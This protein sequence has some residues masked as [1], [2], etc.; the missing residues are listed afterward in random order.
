MKIKPNR[1]SC[2]IAT[3]ELSDAEDQDFLSNLRAHVKGNNARRKAEGLRSLYVKV[4][5]RLGE[6]NPNAEKYR[7]RPSYTNPYQCVKLGDARFGDIYVYERYVYDL[8]SA[9]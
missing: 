3:I 9:A 2:Y 8:K 6:D 4:Q 7:G 5:G 1:T